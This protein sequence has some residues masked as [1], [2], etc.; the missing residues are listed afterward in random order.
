MFITTIGPAV[1][2]QNVVNRHFKSLLRHAGLPNIAGTISAYP[3]H[4]QKLLGH[5]SL[6]LTLDRYSHWTLYGQAHRECD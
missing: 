3:T 2:A 5:P 1:D 4:A 6:Q